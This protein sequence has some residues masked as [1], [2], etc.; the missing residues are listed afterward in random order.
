M[1]FRSGGNEQAYYRVPGHSLENERFDSTGEVEHVK[2]LHIGN[3]WIQQDVEFALSQPATL[4]R[5]SIET[6]TGSEA[7]FERNH[8]GSCL[9]LLWLLLLEPGQSWQVEIACTGSADLSAPGKFLP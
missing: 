8:Q 9:T 2:T 6:V 4:W 1:L 5:Y 3:T 7:G